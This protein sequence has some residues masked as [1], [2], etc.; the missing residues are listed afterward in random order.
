VSNWK[1]GDLS[2]KVVD[3]F[4][5]SDLDTSQ[6]L[7]IADNYS[8]EHDIHDIVLAT[9]KGNT[10]L[11]ASDIFQKGM[12]IV[13]VT[14]STGFIKENF[15]ELEASISKNIEEKG[16]KILSSVMPFH[17]WNDHYR[18]RSGAIMPTTII[19]DTLRLFGQGTKVCV[20]IVMMA[21]DAGMI[22]HGQPVLAIA[23]TGKGAD[24]VLSMVGC[25]SRKFF[26]MKIIDVIA[27]PRSW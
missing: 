8:R 12:N 3:M 5:T 1:S 21:C 7:A 18:K 22:P 16:I 10:A 25:N 26:D 11:T 6:V 20:E 4:D 24:T 9:T 17:S 23:G 14:H 15:Q 13:A 27:K 19:A 2:N